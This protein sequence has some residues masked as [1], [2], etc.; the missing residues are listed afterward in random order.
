MINRVSEPERVVLQTEPGASPPGARETVAFVIPLYDEE[1]VVPLLVRAV[2]AYRAAH[3]E[4]V[5]VV[6]VDDGSCDRTKL[7]RTSG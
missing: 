6:L 5:Q 3:P 1:A 2:E 7:E 4:V